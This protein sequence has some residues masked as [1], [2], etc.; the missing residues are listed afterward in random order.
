MNLT[1]WV[2]DMF[3]WGSANYDSQ[4]KSLYILTNVDLNGFWFQEY[5]FCI[6]IN[7]QKISTSG[8]II[9]VNMTNEG[10]TNINTNYTLTNNE[11][12]LS[13]N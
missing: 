13:A 4:V 10:N 12:T 2:N 11:L 5:S 9:R 8:T 7:N 6:L 1:T 3:R